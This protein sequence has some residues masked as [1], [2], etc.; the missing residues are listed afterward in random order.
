MSES[1]EL[2]LYGRSKAEVED[3]HRCLFEWCAGKVLGDNTPA[4]ERIR[5]SWATGFRLADSEGLVEGSKRLLALQVRFNEAVDDPL[6]A[7]WV[8]SFTGYQVGEGLFQAFY[9]EWQR[10]VSGAEQGRA[11]SV[12]L[13]EAPHIFVT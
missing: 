8:E 10:R 6:Q 7:V 1:D 11:W 13:R 12:L 4:W 2:D 3:L 5:A 9:E